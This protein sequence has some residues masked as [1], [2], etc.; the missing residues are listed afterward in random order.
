MKKSHSF[1]S[2]PIF[3]ILFFLIGTIVF[4]I[5]IT[6]I[7][8]PVYETYSGRVCHLDD[9]VI[10]RTEET[11]PKAEKVFYFINRNEW[12]ESTCEY[13]TQYSGYLMENVRELKDDTIVEVDIPI[14]T[15]SLLDAIFKKGGNL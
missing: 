1:L 13:S 5:M 2:S 4:I 15:I 9:K 8:I 12:I 3:Y 10:I 11:A 14:K 6:Q 7:D